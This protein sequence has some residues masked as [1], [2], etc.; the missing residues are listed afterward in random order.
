MKVN[1]IP[2]AVDTY[3]GLRCMSKDLYICKKETPCMI[4]EYLHCHERGI[5]DVV[6]RWASHPYYTKSKWIQYKKA[7][8]CLDCAKEKKYAESLGPPKVQYIDPNI[9]KIVRRYHTPEV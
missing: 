1:N 6:L 3:N 8:L 4:I 7:E 2:I 9:I 5:I